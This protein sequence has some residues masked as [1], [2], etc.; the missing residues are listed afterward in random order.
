M[1]EVSSQRSPFGVAE[2]LECVVVEDVM[3]TAGSA[4][5]TV[6]GARADLS[7]PPVGMVIG[8]MPVNGSKVSRASKADSSDPLEVQWSAQS[9][10]NSTVRAWC[11]DTQRCRCAP[12]LYCVTAAHDVGA[13]TTT[14]SGSSRCCLS[15]PMEVSC[16]TFKS[17]WCGASY[18]HAPLLPA[19]TTT[20]WR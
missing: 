20:T 14:C 3:D 11:I 1:E 4:Q 7:P 18:S 9:Q 6:H 12:L 13:L 17:Y 16:I 2:P 8:S 15:L 5:P 19:S 10:A